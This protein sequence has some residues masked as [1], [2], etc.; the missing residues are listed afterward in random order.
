MTKFKSYEQVILARD[1][2]IQKMER[3]VKLVEAYSHDGLICFDYEF[4][5]LLPPYPEYTV[6]DPVVQMTLKFELE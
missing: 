6:D 5:V 3:T 2:I 4:S 1:E